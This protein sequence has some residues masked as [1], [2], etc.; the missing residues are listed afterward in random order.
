M[1]RAST[2]RFR[3]ESK[4]GE[5]IV[6]PPFRL[7]PDDTEIF[8]HVYRNR[9][10]DS[11]SIYRLF[12]H[13]S[14]QRLSR[15]LKALFLAH[16]LGRPPR[17][18]E[19]YRPGGGSEHFVYGLDREGA[20]VLRGILQMDIPI[21]HWLQ[22]NTEIKKT[23]IDHTLGVTRFMVNLELAARKR[24]NIRLIRFDEIITKLVPERTR[25][26]RDPD[27]WQ[28]PI[29]WNGHEG[30]EGTRP[31]QIFGIE[32][33]DRPE[34]KN[35][36]FFFFGQDEGSETIE[37]GERQRKSRQFFRSSSFLRKMIVY[38]FSHHERMHERHFGFAATPR[39]LTVTTTPERAANMRRL[40]DTY[41]KA[42]PLET[43]PG[44]FLFA[45]V[46]EVEA[47][48]EDILAMPWTNCAGQQVFL[49]GR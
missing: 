46:A 15:R 20:R 47:H 16:Y 12:P 9:L 34:G 26:R 22:K 29:N 35:R 37:P 10:I 38:A 19:L 36:A 48:G 27:R 8:L 25:N 4:D 39:I 7:T 44:L 41:L 13:R 30:K 24:Q 3:R 1:A 2:P 17:Q 18:I 21:Y 31:D 45:S 32:Y 23:N 6:P 33:L 42:K 40:Y 43:K 49:D 14:E 28:A 5:V 11:A